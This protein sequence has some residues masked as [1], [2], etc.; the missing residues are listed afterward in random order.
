MGV[1]WRCGA[2]EGVGRVTSVP[3]PGAH[4]SCRDA[5]TQG[6]KRTG[7]G[8]RQCCV[9]RAYQ[10]K[11]LVC[12]GEGWVEGRGGRDHAPAAPPPEPLSTRRTGRC[13]PSP[14]PLIPTQPPELLPRVTLPLLL[15]PQQLLHVLP[16]KAVTPDWSNRPQR[17]VERRLRWSP[18]LPQRKID[19]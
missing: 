2:C 3:W 13:K 9:V 4:S 16:P 7:A 18:P 10:V 1:S 5:T 8:E 6:P 15:L 17:N 19:F 11:R 12:G 14:P